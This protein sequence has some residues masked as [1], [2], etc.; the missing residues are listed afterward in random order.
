MDTTLSVFFNTD[1]IYVTLVEY[2]SDGLKL[3]YLNS[4]DHRFDAQSCD[5]DDSMM[6]AQELEVILSDIKNDVARITITLPSESVIV[7]QFPGSTGL[8][9]Q[10]LRQLVDLEIR[11][12]YPQFNFS[13]FTIELIPLVK[14]LEGKEKMMA[15]IIPNSELRACSELLAQFNLPVTSIEI[16]QM[17]AHNSFTY[18][19]PELAGKNVA[20][21]GIQNNFMDI[22]M[23]CGRKPA[24]YALE[25]FTE[26]SAIGE[27]IENNLS[28]VLATIAPT[29]DGAFFFG[30]GL[31]KDVMM[32]CWE[33][34]MM[35]GIEAKRLNAFRMLRSELGSREREYCSRTLQLF[36]PCIGG[37]FPAYHERLKLY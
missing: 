7:T 12:V 25:S 16:A 2:Q 8:P 37:S 13:D 17:N 11:Q 5:D 28:R 29:I 14:S 34:S 26:T 35:L 4:T 1:R 18:N 24:F 3:L 19:Y 21:I 23:V 10:A 30:N 20:I 33:T 32:S 15:V 22:S 27:I 36:P 31:T 6:A 9:E